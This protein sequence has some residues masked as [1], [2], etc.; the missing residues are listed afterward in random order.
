M[1][2]FGPATWNGGLREGKA[3]SR[4]RA[5]RWKPIPTRSS[6]ATMKSRAPIRRNG[7]HH[8]KG[9]HD[10]RD[11]TMPAVGRRVTGHQNACFTG[12]TKVFSNANA[13]SLLRDEVSG[14][15]RASHAMR[16][17]VSISS[18][19]AASTRLSFNLT[20]TKAVKAAIFRSNPTRKFNGLRRNSLW[21]LNREFSNA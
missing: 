18:N 6:A 4:P 2:R 17:Q 19:S 3:R 1:K 5:A 9:E 14:S 16:K 7:S 11:V 21:R 13:R 10:E 12:A 20:K 15:R 8:G